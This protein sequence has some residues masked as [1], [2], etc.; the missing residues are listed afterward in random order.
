MLLTELLD[1]LLDRVY[2]KLWLIRALVL[3]AE[4]DLVEK[5]VIV[6]LVVRLLLEAND[7]CELV[8]RLIH[9]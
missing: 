1:K 4:R 5:L 3:F 9:L 2:H 7:H 6:L 8:D